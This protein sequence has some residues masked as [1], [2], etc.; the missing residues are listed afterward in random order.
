M[1]QIEKLIE[2]FQNNPSSISASDLG[3][4][5]IYKGGVKSKGKGSHTNYKMPN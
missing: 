4:L 2:K 1:T 3:K 5:I